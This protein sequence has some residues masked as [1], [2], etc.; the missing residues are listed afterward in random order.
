MVATVLNSAAE[1]KINLR[2]DF[3]FQSYLYFIR[4][5]YICTYTHL[6]GCKSSL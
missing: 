5:Y 4:M 2:M 6:R 1:G 3:Y